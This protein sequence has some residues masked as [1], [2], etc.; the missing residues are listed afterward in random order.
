MLV[1]SVVVAIRLPLTAIELVAPS[2][3]AAPPP[4]AAMRPSMPS[5]FICDFCVVLTSAWTAVAKANAAN[6]PPVTNAERENFLDITVLP[7]KTPR[8]RARGRKTAILVQHRRPDETEGTDGCE[9]VAPH[10]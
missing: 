4:M 3:P 7:R 6:N 8:P 9:H 2:L 5:I 10:F 1:C